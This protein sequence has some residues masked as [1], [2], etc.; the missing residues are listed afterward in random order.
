MWMGREGGEEAPSFS[1]FP[2]VYF[3]THCRVHLK[4]SASHCIWH[5]VHQ[6]LVNYMSWWITLHHANPI[7]ASMHCPVKPHRLR[8]MLLNAQLYLFPIQKLYL[9]STVIAVLDLFPSSFPAVVCCG[10]L[11][12]I[13]LTVSL[14]A[15]ID[16]HV[17]RPPIVSICQFSGFSQTRNSVRPWSYHSISISCRSAHQSSIFSPFGVAGF[18]GCSGG[19]MC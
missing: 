11:T 13:L 15:A 17:H 16:G 3:N 19:H 7:R 6:Q 8:S 2:C 18:R 9:R 12:S 4:P 10:F 14:P 1:T 5:N